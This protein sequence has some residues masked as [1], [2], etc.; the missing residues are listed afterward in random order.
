[1][2][3][4]IERLL[5]GMVTALRTDIVPRLDDEYAAGQALAIVDLL[6]NLAG[7]VDWAVAPLRAK[8]ASQM[9]LMKALDELLAGDDAHPG[10]TPLPTVTAGTGAGVELMAACDAM[11]ARIGEIV[12]W[13]GARAAEGPHAEA[14]ALIRT[15]LK[16][17][18]ERDLSLT[19]RPLFAEISRGRDSTS[20]PAEV[21]PP[22]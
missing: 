6:Q 21:P 11:D 12:R 19:A 17:D 2:N 15:H 3:N 5:A 20:K 1:M 18:L 14:R 8:L 7:R 10:T 4:S 16:R 13:L 9:D 22:C